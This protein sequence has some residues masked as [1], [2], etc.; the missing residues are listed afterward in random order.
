[1]APDDI[2]GFSVGSAVMTTDIVLNSFALQ[3][4]FTALK[5]ES[6]SGLVLMF[7]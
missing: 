7:L 4:C 6:W 1:M 2:H 5:W 3:W